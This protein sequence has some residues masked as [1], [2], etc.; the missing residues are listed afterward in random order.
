MSPVNQP[1][2]LVPNPTAP[3]KPSEKKPSSF[4]SFLKTLIYAVLIALV[5][6]IL[7]Y[8]PFNIP[9]KFMVPT[10]LDGDYVFVSL[11]SLTMIWIL[12]LA[13]SA[14]PWKAGCLGQYRKGVTLS[15]SVCLKMAKPIT[16]NDW[17]DYQA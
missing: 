15:C 16:S 9:T 13:F 11:N 17:W 8:E 6:R 4:G 3:Q 7:A 10:L 14:C 1:N 2:N 5:I 12:L